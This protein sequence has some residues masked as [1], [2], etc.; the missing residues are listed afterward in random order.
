MNSA[1]VE[2]KKQL[3]KKTAYTESRTVM[4]INP[5]IIEEM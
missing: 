3:K 5:V 4:L 1:L 2:K